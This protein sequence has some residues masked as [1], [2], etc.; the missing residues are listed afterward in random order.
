MRPKQKG[1][2]CPL[3][4]QENLDFSGDC[5]RLFRNLL[6]EVALYR[7]WGRLGCGFRFRLGRSLLFLRLFVLFCRGRLLIIRTY[8]EGARLQV[9]LQQIRT[10]AFRTRFS[11]RFVCRRKVA[12]WLVRAPIKDVAA[13]ACFLLNQLTIFA[14]GTLHA[15][16]VLFYV[17]ALR[18]T[19]ARN[20]FAVS[21]VTENH[22]AS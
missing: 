13:P 12:V 19:A 6:G 4:L 3:R 20:E 8:E 5:Y 17:L 21:A 11:H 10:A 2:S 14:L 16:E 7:W 22:I 18:I 9:L 1:R 15:N